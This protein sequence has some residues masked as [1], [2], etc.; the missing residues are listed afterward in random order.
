MWK[1]TKFSEIFKVELLIKWKGSNHK[2]HL[3][4][5]AYLYQYKPGC[6]SGYT[7]F[8]EG[9]SAAETR[10]RI[11]KFWQW[12]GLTEC[13]KIW[14]HIRTWWH[15]YISEVIISRSPSL[16]LCVFKDKN[17]FSNLYVQQVFEFAFVET[18]ICF[19][20]SVP[21][22]LWYDIGILQIY[23]EY[24]RIKTYLQQA[25]HT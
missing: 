2:P 13:P 12:S 19:L 7:H 8:I 3:W 14:P 17:S 5:Q 10:E 23:T 22:M 21:M 4:I 16:F 15:Q 24:C 18:L 6:G 25:M 9:A 11:C 20:V 1:F